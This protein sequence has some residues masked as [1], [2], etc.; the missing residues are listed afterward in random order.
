LAVYNTNSSLTFC[1]TI[2]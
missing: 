2:K 1:W